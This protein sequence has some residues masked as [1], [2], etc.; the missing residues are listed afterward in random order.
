MMVTEEKVG[1]VVSRIKEGIGEPVPSR[2]PHSNNLTLTSGFTLQN[3]FSSLHSLALFYCKETAHLGEGYRDRALF[4]P[5]SSSSKDFCFEHEPGW[6]F[7]C[8]T[9][10]KMEADP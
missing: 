3:C 1:G 9:K 5:L 10:T 7:L 8:P 6:G 4:E 2:I